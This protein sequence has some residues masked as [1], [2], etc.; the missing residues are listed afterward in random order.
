[1]TGENPQVIERIVGTLS[2][3][4]VKWSFDFKGGKPERLKVIYHLKKNGYEYQNSFYI[5]K[6]K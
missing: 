2:M 6:I 1:M 5:K 4:D 3:I